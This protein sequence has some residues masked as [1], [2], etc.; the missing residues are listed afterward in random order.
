VSL[1]PNAVGV[2]TA[3]RTVSWTSKDAIL[4]ALGVGAGVDDLR[5]T[6]ENTRHLPQAVLPTFAITVG[7]PTNVLRDVG[8][9]DWGH[10]VHG[11][12]RTKLFGPLPTDGTA[13]VVE[14]VVA[15]EDKGEGKSGVVTTAADVIDCETKRLLAEVTMTVVIRGA[16]G[17]GGVSR[18]SDPQVQIPSNDPD[19]IRRFSTARDQALLY[20]LSGDRNPLHSDPSYATKRAGFPRPILHGLCTY[21]FAGRA[22]LSCA[23]D[24]DVARF[25]ELSGRFSKPVYPGEELAVRIWR[26]QEGAVFQVTAGADERVVFDGGT[27]FVRVASSA[28]SDRGATKS[29]LDGNHDGQ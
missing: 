14:R 25:G 23:C 5:Y 24:D 2:Q 16:G 29:E 13:E 15:I 12:Q 6:T 28:E 7:L 17:F 20:R 21:G 3:P 18:P 9:F 22:L 27:F 1:D 8:A 19:D 26:Q 10:L 11:G 4:Y